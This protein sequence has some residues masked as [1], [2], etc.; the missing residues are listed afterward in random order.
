MHWGPGWSGCSAVSGLRHTCSGSRR[1]HGLKIADI[2]NHIGKSVV[3]PLFSLSG[4]LFFSGS[5]LLVF[6][7]PSIPPFVFS[8]FSFL[9]FHC[10]HSV[11]GAWMSLCVGDHG[12]VAGIASHGSIL[13]SRGWLITVDAPGHPR[14]PPSTKLDA[15]VNFD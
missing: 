7:L 2:W 4:C 15:V 11:T 12:W 14:H 6:C 1:S 8:F 10:Y 9:S 13:L 3:Q 5:A